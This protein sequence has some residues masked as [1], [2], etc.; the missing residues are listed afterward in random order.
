[1]KHRSRVKHPENPRRN[2]NS[3]KDEFFLG[4]KAGLRRIRL[5][6]DR[7]GR[8]IAGVDIFSQGI[9]DN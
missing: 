9:S 6:D 1:M 5:H 7:P 3:G 8:N 4:D 2:L